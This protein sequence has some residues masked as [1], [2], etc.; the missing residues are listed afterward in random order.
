MHVCLDLDQDPFFIPFQVFLL[1]F[2]RCLVWTSCFR[3]HR[4]KNLCNLFYRWSSH[5]LLTNRK[6]RLLSN[7]NLKSYLN[8]CYRRFLVKLNWSNKTSFFSLF[9]GSIFFLRH[10]KF[11]L[12]EEWKKCNFIIFQVIWERLF[13]LKNYVSKDNLTNYL[14]KL[15]LWNNFWHQLDNRMD[16]I[17]VSIGSKMKRFVLDVCFLIDKHNFRKIFCWQIIGHFT[18]IHQ[19]TFFY[20]S[21][22]L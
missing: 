19:V 18:N 20:L 3:L 4:Q 17:N 7:S 1:Q 12:G 8:L 13:W 15:R 16:K 22:V 21:V 11:L 2:Q 5:S 9:R 10:L 6:D 14:L